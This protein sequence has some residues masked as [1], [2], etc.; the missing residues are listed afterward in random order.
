MPDPRCYAY[1]VA[2]DRRSRLSARG[3]VG[4]PGDNAYVLYSSGSL[5]VRGVRSAGCGVCTRATAGTTTSDERGCDRASGGPAGARGP[6]AGVGNRPRHDLVVWSLIPG[7]TE[8]RRGP[9]RTRF[10]EVFCR[11]GVDMD[12]GSAPVTVDALFPSRV[13]VLRVGFGGGFFCVV[14]LAVRA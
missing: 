4:V 10:A 14:V 8:T 2:N 3:P 11:V 5:T 12:M 1:L 7:K 9:T 13:S 6:M